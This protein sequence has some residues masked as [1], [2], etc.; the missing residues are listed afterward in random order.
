MAQA[1]AEA[2]RRTTTRVASGEEAKAL[3]ELQSAQEVLA[4]VKEESEGRA[5]TRG[6]GISTLLSP[7]DLK[8]AET[9][10]QNAQKKVAEV[11]EPKTIKVPDLNPFHLLNPFRL[12]RRALKGQPVAHTIY[13]F[14]DFKTQET[15][16]LGLF[17]KT[18]VIKKYTEV[19]PG[20]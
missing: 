19:L 14:T 18:T 5:T 4:E 2:D 16:F 1:A 10:V 7:V 3:I 6:G 9:R 15:R 8:G 12:A 13:Q 17:P 20:E 11:L